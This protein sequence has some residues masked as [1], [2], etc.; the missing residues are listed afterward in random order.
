MHASRRGCSNSVA[1]NVRAA[2]VADP[3]MEWIYHGSSKPLARYKPSIFPRTAL[4]G[5]G[6]L[7]LMPVWFRSDEICEWSSQSLRIRISGCSQSSGMLWN[8]PKLFKSKLTW[9]SPL[10]GESGIASVAK[11]LSAILRGFLWVLCVSVL[12]RSR[13]LLPL[14]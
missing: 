8:T 3:V 4:P 6:T 11:K 2:M 10:S 14:P 5:G 1:I 9:N 13:H 12:L 7:L